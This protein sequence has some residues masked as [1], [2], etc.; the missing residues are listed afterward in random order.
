MSEGVGGCCGCEVGKKS[1]VSIQ[2]SRRIAL[3]HT[4]G[5]TIS[6]LQASPSFEMATRLFVDL[7]PLR[8]RAGHSA[9]MDEVEARDGSI[10]P[11]FICGSVVEFEEEIRRCGGGLEGGGDVCGDDFSGGETFG[12][13]DGPVGGTGAD[14]E[15]SCD[16]GGGGDGGEG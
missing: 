7:R 5:S 9:D 15:D 2:V 6:D 8:K 11:T 14:V 1:V 3:L 10:S 12:D 16:G 4:Y 13:G